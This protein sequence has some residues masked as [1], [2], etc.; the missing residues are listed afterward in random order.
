MRVRLTGLGA[1]ALHVEV[2]GYLLVPDLGSFMTEQ[3]DLILSMNKIMNYC[4][5][6]FAF[7]SRTIYIAEDTTASA[8]DVERIEAQYRQDKA[9]NEADH[10]E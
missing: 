3:E 8:D 2:F 1:N 5:S 7:P 6:G 10:A 9:A 4:G